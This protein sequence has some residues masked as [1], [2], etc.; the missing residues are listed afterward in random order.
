MFVFYEKYKLFLINPFELQFV[1][2]LC[3]IVC[4]YKCFSFIQKKKNQIIQILCIVQDQNWFVCSF[5]CYLSFIFFNRIKNLQNS[6]LII[7]F[8]KNYKYI[9]KNDN[10]QVLVFWYLNAIVYQKKIQIY[11]V[12]LDVLFKC[13]SVYESVLFM[14]FIVQTTYR[15][16]MMIHVF[17][18][19]W[20]HRFFQCRF[21]VFVSKFDEISLHFSSSNDLSLLF[22]II[23]PL[24]VDKYNSILQCPCFLIVCYIAFRTMIDCLINYKSIFLISRYIFLEI[25]FFL[26]VFWPFLYWIK[27]QILFQQCFKLKSSQFKLLFQNFF[28][29]TFNLKGT[30]SNCCFRI[31]QLYIKLKRY[32]IDLLFQNFFSLKY[33]ELNI[34]PFSQLL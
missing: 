2:L 12:L 13:V 11:I 27:I 19:L 16:V 8:L 15:Y 21:D 17:N 34:A 3:M 28:C 22:L 24:M 31:L 26:I 29:C 18:R 30:K 23:N 32:Q 4:L 14:L 1:C 7:I 25:V 9:V 5:E 10:Q 33:S 6:K 20:L